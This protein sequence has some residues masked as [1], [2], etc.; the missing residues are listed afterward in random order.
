MSSMLCPFVFLSPIK[1][2]LV[3]G[4]NYSY[5]ETDGCWR[6]EADPAA[7]NLPLPNSSEPCKH[8]KVDVETDDD[9]AADLW[10][11]CCEHPLSI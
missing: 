2:R 7:E 1:E 3:T 10:D 5:L 9:D 6:W 11:L 4:G 8:G